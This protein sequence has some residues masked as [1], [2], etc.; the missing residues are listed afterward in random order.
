MLDGYKIVSVTPAGRRRYIDVLAK[1]LLAERGLIDQHEWWV[2]TDS[3]EDIDYLQEI[4]RENPD[5]FRIVPASSSAPTGGTRIELHGD[6]CCRI[7]EWF[8]RAIASDT[9]YIRLDDDIVYIAPGAIYNLL[10]FR[11]DHPEPFLVYPCIIN[12]SIISH[13]LQRQGAI[14]LDQGRCDYDTWGL[15]WKDGSFAELVHRTFLSALENDDMTDWGFDKWQLHYY[16]RVSINCIVWF[17]HDFATFCGQVGRDE[18]P[19]LTTEMPS[20]LARPNI[21]CGRSIVAHFSYY[22]QN[23][24][25]DK[26]DLLARYRSVQKRILNT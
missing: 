2:N 21:I 6:W 20:K 19:F 8:P 15:G 16:E 23:A 24:H 22:A 9:I 13:I 17:G 1:Y 26:T 3:S 18:E 4:T 5:F 11:I 12:N 10:R 25:M 14:P 7:S